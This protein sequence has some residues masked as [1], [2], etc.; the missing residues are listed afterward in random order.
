MAQAMAMYARGNMAGPYV[1]QK[2]YI[3]QYYAYPQQKE[4]LINWTIGYEESKS[5]KM[6]KVTISVDE[7][8]EYSVIYGEIKKY[9][10]T[11]IASF[12]TGTE[13]FSKYDEFIA[14]LKQL[15]VDRAIEIQQN[16]YNS[17]QK[18]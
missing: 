17:Y 11:M 6:P 4:A 8:S 1:Q 2:E 9:V 16:A 12:I 10:T 5:H 15:K 13:P 3:E 18:R 7:Q 14:N